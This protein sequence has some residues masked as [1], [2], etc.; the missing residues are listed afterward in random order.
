MRDYRVDDRLQVALSGGRLVEAEVNPCA[1]RQKE[2]D[3]RCQIYPW[4]IVIEAR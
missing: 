4:Q 2:H 3:C 1:K